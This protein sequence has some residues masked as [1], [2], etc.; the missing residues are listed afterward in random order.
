MNRNSTECGKKRNE[1]K[2]KNKKRVRVHSTEE[3]KQNEKIKGK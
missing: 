3:N 2:N 1:N